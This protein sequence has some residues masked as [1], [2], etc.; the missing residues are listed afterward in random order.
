MVVKIPK[1]LEMK[2]LFPA[3]RSRTSF[4]RKAISP[5]HG[6]CASRGEYCERNLRAPSD[7]QSGGNS[8]ATNTIRSPPK[9]PSL[10]IYSPEKIDAGAQSTLDVHSCLAIPPSIQSFDCPAAGPGS[11]GG[12]VHKRGE[13]GCKA[14]RGRGRHASE[15]ARGRAVQANVAPEGWVPPAI[16][17]DRHSNV[18]LRPREATGPDVNADIGQQYGLLNLADDIGHNLDCMPPRMATEWP[19][20]TSRQ[21]HV[22]ADV[23]VPVCGSRCQISL[24]GRAHT[25][26]GT[27]N[28]VETPILSS[29]IAGRHSARSS[30]D[31]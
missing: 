1:K 21:G 13:S 6:A 16:L 3:P 4:S 28:P 30:S 31:Q 14:P 25:G 23:D 20:P 9:L 15:T 5:N 27:D 22:G 2:S 11:R 24:Q 18:V 7:A 19:P 12:R 26:L 17:V 10:S 8:S 29:T